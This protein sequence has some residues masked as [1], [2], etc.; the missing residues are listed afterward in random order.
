MWRGFYRRE[1]RTSSAY[2]YFF[3][4]FSPELRKVP[5]TGR[6]RVLYLVLI[7]TTNPPEQA[8]IRLNILRDQASALIKS[9]QYLEHARHSGRN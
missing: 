5:Q 9:I 3:A 4:P 6:L 8:P 1:P 7:I 2:F